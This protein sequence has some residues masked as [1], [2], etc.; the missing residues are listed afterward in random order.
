MFNKRKTPIFDRF[1]PNINAPEIM[2]F[3]LISAVSAVIVIRM[4]LLV[5]G[6]PQISGSGLHISHMILGGF[7]M[8]S[9]LLLVFGFINADI[10][11]ISAVIGGIGFGTFIDELGKFITSD[12]NYFYEP[13][14]A[15]IYLIFVTIFLLMKL[16]NS[17][18]KPSKLTY[19]ANSVELLKDMLCQGLD[20]K[21]RKKA[22]DYLIRCSDD[23]PLANALK[24]VFDTAKFHR[25]HT[26]TLARIGSYF[27]TVDTRIRGSML[28][29]SVT[30]CIFFIET[31]TSMLFSIFLLSSTPLE[32]FTLGYFVSAV[33]TG[34][35]VL[36][37]VILYKRR[38]VLRTYHVFIYSILISIFIKQYFLFVSDPMLALI[39]L[40]IDIFVY[41]SL[42]YQI[43]QQSSASPAGLL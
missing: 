9:A 22:I 2:E 40:L 12:N 35:L 25:R 13:A 30:F 39:T 27:T 3:F 26:S 11:K 14:I 38:R 1:V 17:R 10:R 5:T 18:S 4:F 20:S 21:N 37:G 28:F 43:N 8:L 33:S 42:K 34:L 6:Y 7:M 15:L 31:L 29:R 32:L 16:V 24:H 23:E 19:L 36:T 41:T